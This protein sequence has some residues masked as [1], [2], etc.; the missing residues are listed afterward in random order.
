MIFILIIVHGQ[1]LST[2]DQA[3]FVP[4]QPRSIVHKK[5][6]MPLSAKTQGML[7]SK[8]ISIR[9]PLFGQ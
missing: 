2:P 6:I 9:C 5:E 1:P 4:R 3:E 8:P 7:L